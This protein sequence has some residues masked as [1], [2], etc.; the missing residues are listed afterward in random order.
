V[1]PNSDDIPLAE[2]ARRLSVRAHWLHEIRAYDSPNWLR[3]ARK[4]AERNGKTDLPS[5]C[6]SCRGFYRKKTA[7]R[8]RFSTS[9]GLKARNGEQ[10]IP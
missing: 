2:V 1:M 7:L 5:R 10:D 6:T 9:D 4:S 3:S 8:Q